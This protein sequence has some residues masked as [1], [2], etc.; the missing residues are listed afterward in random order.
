MS[1][2][3]ILPIYDA[4]RLSFTDDRFLDQVPAH[5]IWPPQNYRD[6][7]HDDLFWKGI[8]RAF[9]FTSIFVPGMIMIP[10]VIAVLLDRVEN[11]RLSTFYRII[12]L[13]P[14]MIPAPLIVILFVWLYNNYIGPINYILVDVLHIYD[15]R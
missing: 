12:L 4:L 3:Q 9:I 7:L 10:M 5:S 13:I 1:G 14:S 2:G 11:R 6:L 15:V 8:L